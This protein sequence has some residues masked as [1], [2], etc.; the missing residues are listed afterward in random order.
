MPEPILSRALRPPGYDVCA[1]EADDATGVLSGWS[2]MVITA[3]A[4]LIRGVH[5]TE[6]PE[7]ARSALRPFGSKRA[8]ALA[9]APVYRIN[10]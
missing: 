3:A 4:T 8:H 7:V 2:V 9:V 10:R 1:W 5:I 6:T